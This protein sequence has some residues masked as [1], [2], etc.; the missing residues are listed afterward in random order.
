MFVSKAEY[1]KLKDMVANQQ[2]LLEKLQ[3]QPVLI[4]IERVGRVNKF[5]FAIGEETYVVETMGMLNDNV[6]EWKERLL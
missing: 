1:E 5:T 3:A 2:Q 6:P 4:G